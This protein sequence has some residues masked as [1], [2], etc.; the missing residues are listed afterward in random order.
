MS[1]RTVASNQRIRDERREQILRAAL[2]VF[3]HKGLDATKISDIAAA[4][5]IS[6]GLIHHYFSSKQSVYTAVA[7]RAMQGAMETLAEPTDPRS[8]PWNRLVATCERMLDGISRYPE[9]LL[10][11]VQC[12]VNEDIPPETRAL[13]SQYGTSLFSHMVGLIREGQAAGQVVAGAPEE[14]AMTFAAMIQ[15]LVLTQFTRQMFVGDADPGQKG[16]V[17]S[18]ETVLRLLKG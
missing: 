14:L 7:E 18:T 2:Q 12:L 9:Y 15:G 13:I 3:A 10:V 1:P 6:Q 17:P 5:G 11:I 16:T 4:A 8:T